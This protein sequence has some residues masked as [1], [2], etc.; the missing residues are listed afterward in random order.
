MSQQA[1]APSH[2]DQLRRHYNELINVCL[3]HGKADQ[4]KEI[5]ML[6]VKQGVW[7]HPMQRPLQYVPGIP[8]KPVYDPSQYWFV[9]YLEEHYAQIRE[10]V[11]TVTDPR[12]QGFNP[13]EEPLLDRGRW[14]QVVF[15]EAG[16]RFEQACNRF[17]V[18]AAVMAGIP[19]ATT[20]GP[21]VVT[22]SWLY[23]GTHIIPHCGH[24]NARLRIHLGIKVPSGV[25]IRVGD[26]MF[27]WKEGKCV[28]FDDSFE[29]EIWHHGTEPRVVLL[30]DVLNPTLSEDE[31]ARLLQKRASLEDRIKAFMLEHGLQ[32]IDA[33]NDQLQFLPN[34][35]MATVVR[36]YMQDNHTSVV[37]MRGGK[38][39]FE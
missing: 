14:D 33:S 3:A 8:S 20:F 11:E 35:S 23:P 2:A 17:P 38:L 10:E 31:K 22:L 37:E 21:G 27:T 4:A 18:T 12:R 34:E 5:A 19:D 9:R 26:Q 36:R 16:H 30:F 6:A 24:S 13:V 7:G 28:V 29:H 32:R 1:V 25:S 15:Y 39:Y